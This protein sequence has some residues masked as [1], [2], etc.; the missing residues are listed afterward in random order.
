MGSGLPD[1]STAPAATAPVPQTAFENKPPPGQRGPKGLAGRQT[2]SRVNTG[3]P[4][5]PD[6]GQSQ[7]KSMAPRGEEFLPKT[8]ELETLMTTTA[9]PRPTLHDFIKTAMEASAAKVDLS[10]E[11]A[12]QVASSGDVL[13]AGKEKTAAATPSSEVPA[14]Y[15]D[16]LANALSFVARSINPKV[17][18]ETA[19]EGP[20]KG[21]NA[22]ETNQG[23]L[24]TGDGVLEAGQ[25]GQSSQ[26][27]AMSPPTAKLPG[28]KGDPGNTMATN[29]DT[30]HPEQPVEPIANEK[31]SSAY[32]NNL[33]ATGLAKVAM[34][35]GQLVVVPSNEMVK[36]AFGAADAGAYAG[37]TL[38]GAAGGSLVGATKGGLAG[39]IGGG[40]LGALGGGLGGLVLGGPGLAATGALAGG[41]GGAAM[42]GTAGGA[43]G[44]L[45]GAVP[46]GISGFQR[47][48]RGGTPTVM[49]EEVK[50]AAAK[51]AGWVGPPPSSVYEAA[52]M[53]APKNPAAF[54]V[55]PSGAPALMPPDI[56]AFTKAV[57]KGMSTLG[58]AGLVG[59]GLAGLAAAGG[60]GYGA[61][62]HLKGKKQE[63]MAEEQAAAAAPEM[64][65]LK[66]ASARLAARNLMVLGLYKQA[67]DAINPA[68]ISAGKADATGSDAPSGAT[69]AEQGVPSEPSDVNKQK[70]LVS[71]N[72]AAIDYTKRDAKADPKSDVGDVVQEPAQTSATDK[73]LDKALDHTDEAGAKISSITRVAAARAILS[74]LAEEMSDKSKKK[75]KQSQGMAPSTPS[76]ASGFSAGT[77][78]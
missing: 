28:Q 34:V 16:K 13:P 40:A 9:M 46:G 41:L 52:G 2:F 70:A 22:L 3:I 44:G 71:S 54:F 18:E 50:S 42:G 37:S 31:T 15:I 23:K 43:L 49:P 24:P 69:P 33:L 75:E 10:L 4:P 51:I 55:P 56:S 62:K 61:Y 59:G 20:G 19:S 58:K 6:A 47:A 78:M 29:V 53:M 45:S 36:Q 77:S 17:A 57:P 38:G 35:Q 68:Q 11:S 1:P 64:E 32:I 7:Q 63:R 65:A 66:A 12:R 8:A 74:K 21:P 27:P 72:Q 76:E 26:A 14:E 30:K 60:I 73:V 48:S 25:S 5:T 67:E 39:G